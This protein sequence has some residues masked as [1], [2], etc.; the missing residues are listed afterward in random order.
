[1]SVFADAADTVSTGFIYLPVRPGCSLQ[2]YEP[3]HRQ[4]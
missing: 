3:P 4:E 2:P 1:V